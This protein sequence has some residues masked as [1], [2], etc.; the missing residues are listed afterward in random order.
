MHLRFDKKILTVAF[1]SGLVLA[2]L[3]YVGVLCMFRI[4]WPG[5][6]T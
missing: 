5:S 6:H 3:V 2:V 4:W 1:Y